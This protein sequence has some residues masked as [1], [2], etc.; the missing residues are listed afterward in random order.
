MID[1]E[2]NRK[3]K[4]S[5]SFKII[6]IGGGLFFVLTGILRILL[7]V[8]D[9]FIFDLYFIINIIYALIGLAW[10][11][12]GLNIFNLWPNSSVKIDDNRLYFNSSPF[13]K[14]ISL[15]WNEIERI[16]IKVNK[17]ILTLKEKNTL[18]IELGWI[19]YNELISI[20]NEVEKLA[21]E[22][23]INCKRI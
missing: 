15:L 21:G 14:T 17:L 18:E 9:G 7:S 23:S 12:Q 20:K 22:K 16:E 13:D 1:F 19:P 3:R 11:L 6:F 5:L 4:E 10:A 8:R 2:L